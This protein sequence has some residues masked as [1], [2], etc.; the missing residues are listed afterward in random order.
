MARGERGREIKV[1]FANVQS[2]VNKVDELKAHLILSNCDIF[3]ATETWAND[4]IGN[5]LL[6]IDGYEI[7]SRL[8]R[9]DT[10]KGR[11]GGIIV[12]AKKEIDI[13][14]TEVKTQFHQCVTV[15]VK[16]GSED[17]NINAI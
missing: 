5:D 15:K 17:V 3:A 7:V 1:S 12:Y 4:D 2:L 16:K 8:D 6:F 9:R 14:N 10:N 13:W 11:G